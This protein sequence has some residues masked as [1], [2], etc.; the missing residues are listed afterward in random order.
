MV[1]MIAALIIAIIVMMIE[2]FW[3]KPDDEENK[4]Q[5]SIA[6]DRSVGTLED[7]DISKEPI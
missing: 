2:I 1:L 7:D 5:V 3:I 6:D 4:S